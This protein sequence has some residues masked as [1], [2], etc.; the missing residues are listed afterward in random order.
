MK[1]RKK[2][3]RIIQKKGLINRLRRIKVE[4]ERYEGDSNFIG[5]RNDS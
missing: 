2:E 4:V 5:K 3:T 1:K